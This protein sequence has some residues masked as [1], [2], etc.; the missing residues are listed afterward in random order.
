MPAKKNRSGKSDAGDGGKK[1]K[2]GSGSGK[3]N[4][5]KDM[6]LVKLQA[7]YD[8][9]A[10][11]VKAL[12]KMAKKATDPLLKEALEKHAVQTEGHVERLKRAFELWGSAAKRLKVEA[13]RGLVADAEWL[14]RTVKDPATRDAGMVSA[15]QY[16]E[17]YEMAGYGTAAEWA[18]IL[19]QGEISGLLQQTL[20]EE[21]DAD[22]SLNELAQSKLNEKALK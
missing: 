12:P 6:L 7:L 21:K 19:G 16:V 15:A 10:Q 13:I 4:S 1:A 5:L 8:I 18:R 14:M 2:G 3:P 22:T 9:E 17:H 20:Q 11:L